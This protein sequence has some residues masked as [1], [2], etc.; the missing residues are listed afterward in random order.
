[1]RKIPHL[2]FVPVL[3]LAGCDLGTGPTPV[4][5][6]DLTEP[7]SNTAVVLITEP[8]GDGRGYY[9]MGADLQYPFQLRTPPPLPEMI[10]DLQIGIGASALT[11]TLA[12]IEDTGIIVTGVDG[13]DVLFMAPDGATY[14]PLT[15][16]RI[17]ITSAWVDSPGARLQ[18]KSDCPV[19]DGSADFRVLFKF[20]YTVPAG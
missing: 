12:N 9:D 10:Y 20:D 7:A 2:L 15:S 3:L 13:V 6:D 18:G 1:M 19:T 16:C 4:T 17:T 14:E 8:L 5:L 11:L